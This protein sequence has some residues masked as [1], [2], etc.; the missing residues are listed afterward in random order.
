MPFLVFY[1]GGKTG[2]LA[3]TPQLFPVSRRTAVK[4]T[5]EDLRDVPRDYL[6]GMSLVTAGGDGREQSVLLVYGIGLPNIDR[7]PVSGLLNMVPYIG[8]VL[9]WLPAFRDCAG[10]I[11]GGKLH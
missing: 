3:G 2:G 8:A 6:V 4:E 5:L 9:A 7:G 10:K 1:V 11:Q